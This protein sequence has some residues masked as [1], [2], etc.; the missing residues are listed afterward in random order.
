MKYKVYLQHEETGNITSLVFDYAGLFTG[1]AKIEIEKLGH[2]WFVIANSRCTGLNTSFGQKMI[3]END[4]FQYKEHKGYKLPNFKAKVV[5]IDDYACFGYQRLLNG[6]W[7]PKVPFAE[8]DELDSDFIS[9]C[10]IIGNTIENGS[11]FE[12]PPHSI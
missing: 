12:R 10:Q 2:R 9:H 11:L 7:C 8:H 1:N 4:I 6:D 3:Y 5:W